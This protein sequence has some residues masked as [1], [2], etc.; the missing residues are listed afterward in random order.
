M[1]TLLILLGVLLGNL[2]PYLYGKMVDAINAGDLKK[3]AALIGGYC[4]VTL[5]TLGM[6]LLEK[7]LGEICSFKMVHSM[8]QTLFE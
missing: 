8:K 7:Y 3:L 5:T 4:A 2:S 6:S 1:I